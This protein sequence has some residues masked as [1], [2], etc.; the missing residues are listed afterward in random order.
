MVDGIYD[1][2]WN[3]FDKAGNEFTT[4]NKTLTI[5]TISPILEFVSPTPENNEGRSN[6]FQINATISEKNL[7]NITYTWN[8]TNFT[9][10]SP[11]NLMEGL[12]LFIPFNNDSNYCENS[13]CFDYQEW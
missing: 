8:R 11:K 4:Q 6:N 9:V 3:I 1:F 10:H 7:A 13:T 5:D 2:F 12:V